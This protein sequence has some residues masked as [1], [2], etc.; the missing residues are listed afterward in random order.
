MNLPT[1]TGTEWFRKLAAE[2]STVSGYDGYEIAEVKLE[3]TNEQEA[4]AHIIKQKGLFVIM[5]AGRAGKKLTMKLIRP[6]KSSDRSDAIS[7]AWGQTGTW[8]LEK[9]REF[10]EAVG[11]ANSIHRG[12]KAIVPGLLMLETMLLDFQKKKIPWKK[13][14]MRFYAPVSAVQNVQILSG[15]NVY[16][17]QTKEEEVCWRMWLS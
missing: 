2:F 13:I 9:I 6:P 16:T 4:E 3:M 5:E 7:T 11:D 10:T 15:E 1:K 17:A 14:K 12:Q 8:P